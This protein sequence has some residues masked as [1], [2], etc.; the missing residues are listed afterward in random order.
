M[1]TIEFIFTDKY[2]ESIPSS[3]NKYLFFC[4]SCEVFIGDLITDKK[5]SNKLQVINVYDT[6]KPIQ[7]GCYLKTVHIDKI[8]HKPRAITIDLEKA[9]NWYFSD[10]ATLKALALSVYNE[11]ELCNSYDYISK[12]VDTNFMTLRVP[13]KNNLFFMALSKLSTIANYYNNG[14]KKI[15]FN[16]GYFIGKSAIGVKAAK[17][18]YKDIY[19][20]K[21]DNVKY[22]GI[23]YFKNKEDVI[24]ALHMLNKEDLDNLF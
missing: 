10:N 8:E 16:T 11:S 9:R 4:S 15:E 22:P 14:W 18:S 19:I 13:F 2:I 12:Q 17:T 20:F 3:I 21:H 6:D 5:Y 24:K 7:N 23:V 1:K